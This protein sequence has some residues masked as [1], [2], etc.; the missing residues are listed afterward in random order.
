MKLLAAEFQIAGISCS[1]GLINIV[2]VAG[3]QRLEFR[4][5]PGEKPYFMS[6]DIIKL[7][8]EGNVAAAAEMT[9]LIQSI[10]AL[11]K[12]EILSKI[13]ETSELQV[14]HTRTG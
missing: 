2:A 11:N 4:V 7:R 6:I 5:L 8:T 3:A 14:H 13:Y 1:W 10:Y 9:A 12:T